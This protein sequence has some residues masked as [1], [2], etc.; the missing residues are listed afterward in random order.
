MK[1]QKNPAPS[2]DIQRK[3]GRIYT[4]DDWLNNEFIMAR[5]YDQPIVNP[6]GLKDWGRML[7]NDS[8]LYYSLVFQ[9]R[10]TYETINKILDCQAET[11]EKIVN[12]E[13]NE[14]V[15]IFNSKVTKIQEAFGSERAIMEYTATIIDEIEKAQL[16]YPEH[17]HAI[18]T[19]K[20]FRN[21]PYGAKFITSAQYQKPEM[22]LP[23]LA[24]RTP[25][26]LVGERNEPL[27]HVSIDPHR[28][29]EGEMEYAYINGITKFK[30]WLEQWKSDTKEVSALS[31]VSAVRERVTPNKGNL[32]QPSIAL[33]Y[34]YN[35]A[36]INK[37]NKDHIARRYNWNSPQSGT[38]ILHEYN[39][40]RKEV[41]RIG[42]T[43]E[44]KLNR[45]R[46]EQLQNEVLPSL[47]GKAAKACR[48]D[49]A[50]AELIKA[51]IEKF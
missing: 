16:S 39:S 31:A 8:E 19:A 18:K 33:I 12:N 14:R 46:L 4:F 3:A 51:D 41:N 36:E 27:A 9:G 43:S 34:F 32:Q 23:S 30:Y 11:Y 1:K 7:L 26:K 44:P 21:M 45:T 40:V 25:N 5:E 38:S 47:K 35:G 24:M 6:D 37:K 50:K 28:M 49:I 20:S 29:C 15:S 2:A 22:V 13:F 42:S 10:I 17:Y 48:E